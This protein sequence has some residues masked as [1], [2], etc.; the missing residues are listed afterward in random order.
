MADNFVS[1]VCP[2]CKAPVEVDMKSKSGIC[3]YCRKPFAC[4]DVLK[5]KDYQDYKNK[6]QLDGDDW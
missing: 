5:Y 3:L 6:Q 2:S 4:K 1:V